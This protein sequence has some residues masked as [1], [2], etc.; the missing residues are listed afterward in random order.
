MDTIKEDERL[1]IV[2]SLTTPLQ[3]NVIKKHAETLKKLKLQEN[4]IRQ[5]QQ[6]IDELNFELSIKDAHMQNIRNETK[7]PITPSLPPALAASETLGP[8]RATPT[9]ARAS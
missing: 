4:E 1:D 5:Q 7:I 3:Q 8:H 6:Q 2:T 9:E